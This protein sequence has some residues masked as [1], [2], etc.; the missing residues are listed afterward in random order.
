MQ[1]GIG[2]GAETIIV[3]EH[4]ESISTIAKSIERG[5]KRGKRSSIIVVAEGPKEGF[6]NRIA[7]GL[8]KKGYEPKVCILGHIQR[9]GEPTAHDRFLASTLGASAVVYLL[10][11]YSDA[12]VGVQKDEIT[13]TPFSKFVGQK[14][15]LPN[16]IIELAKILAT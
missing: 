1:V 15:P 3:P 7:E 16:E 5:L 12:M 8:A 14:K 13:L 2:G 10:A 4:K 11:G 6:T 9:G